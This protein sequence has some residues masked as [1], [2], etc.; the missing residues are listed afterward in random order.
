MTQPMFS[1]DTEVLTQDTHPYPP[2]AL[3]TERLALFANDYL[4]FA[5]LNHYGW[6][7]LRNLRQNTRILIV[8]AGNGDAVV[9]LA[10]QARG[11]EGCDILALETSA[12]CVTLGR[13]RLA[14]RGLTNV[15]YHG[16][17]W[18]DL[19]SANL[20]T[21]DLILC[22]TLSKEED[23]VAALTALR[24]ALAPNG[25]IALSVHAT[26]GL[27]GLHLV[28]TLSNHLLAD[29][30]PRELKIRVVREFL[31]SVPAGH[32]LG[33]NNN[34][35][36]PQLDL[37]NGSGIEAL[38]LALVDQHFTVPEIYGMVDACGLA[39]LSFVADGAGAALYDPASHT[40]SPRLRDI[41]A[42]RQPYEQ[43]IL[44]E[45]MVG[46]I[47]THRF[48]LAIDERTPAQFGDD[49][50][51]ALTP[52]TGTAADFIRI[53]VEELESIPSG[54]RLERTATGSMHVPLVVT[55]KTHTLSLL[56]AMPE[57]A[58]IG[59]LIAHV[60]RE[61]TAKPEKVR[62]DLALLYKELNHAAQAWLQS[63]NIPVYA[64]WGDL[65]ERLSQ[66]PP[67]VL[68]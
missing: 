35:L 42:S 29:Y 25:V 22:E 18:R 53:L 37:A 27:L 43:H 14:K 54:K 50:R 5:V 10:E 8:G 12:A 39:L 36:I 16:L 62:A 9:A 3:E 38:V 67:I 1:L 30:M 64:Y 15:A 49:M 19:A 20:G 44:A 31:G 4:S 51:I 56:R 48:Y 60:A 58:S 11:G 6:S 41:A 7:G 63:G 23:P 59:E 24:E 46:S 13:Q 66:F 45:L 68:N 33:Y 52:A 2:R 26:Y 32:F 34:D 55:H 65:Q 28:Q 57:A 47:Q 61:K 17:G 21:F 40:A